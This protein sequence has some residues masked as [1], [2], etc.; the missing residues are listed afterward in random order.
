[1]HPAVID[2]YTSGELRASFRRATLS[3]RRR[4][5]RGLR[6]P[7]SVALRWLEALPSVREKF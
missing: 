4:P 6:L 7:E 5:V 3:A 1:M 2:Q